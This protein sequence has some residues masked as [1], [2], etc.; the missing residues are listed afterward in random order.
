MW[1]PFANFPHHR[2]SNFP[3]PYGKLHIVDNAY[4][5]FPPK[6]SGIVFHLA[7]IA[8]LTLAGA[9]GLWQAVHSDVGPTF[10]L[11]LLPFLVALPT[12]PFLIYRLNNLENA[13]YTLERDSL[14]LRWGLRVET[15][16]MVDVQWIRPATD[17]RGSLRDAPPPRWRHGCGVFSGPFVGFVGD[18]HIRTV[19]CDFSK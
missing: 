15:I 3:M 12:V 11:Y 2:V 10:L 17:L 13:S 9:W 1:T 5:F 19:V 8:I 14:R 18:C 4:V 16:P 6:R 7:A